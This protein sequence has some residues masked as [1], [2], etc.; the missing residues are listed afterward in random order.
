[1]KASLN[2]GIHERDFLEEKVAQIRAF[3]PTQAQIVPYQTPERA[4][5]KRTTVLRFRVASTKLRIIYNLLYPYRQRRVTRA[6]IELLDERAAA[7]LWAES[8]RLGRGGWILRRVGASPAEARLVA[9]WLEGL[10]GA[11]PTLLG[12]RATPRLWFDHHQ[13]GLLTDAIRHQAPASRLQL[14]TEQVS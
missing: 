7:W 6:A 9:E 12:D 10:T 11:H 3:I 8:A 13:A 14:F 1:M 5:G 2:A 4:S